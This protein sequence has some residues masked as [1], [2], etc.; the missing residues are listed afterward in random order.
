MACHGLLI[1]RAI[2]PDGGGP[3]MVPLDPTAVR[4]LRSWP[5]EPPCPGLLALRHALDY[6][7]PGLWGDDA[8]RPRSVV[9]LRA[10]DGRREAFGAG[11]PGPAVGWLARRP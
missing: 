6:S 10:G 2:R 3:E 11:E 5:G 7:R 1:D 9:L 4:S 8:K